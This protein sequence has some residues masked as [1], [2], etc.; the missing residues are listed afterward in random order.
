MSDSE[1]YAV[2]KGSCASNP[3]CLMSSMYR[4]W[5]KM[6]LSLLLSEAVQLCSLLYVLLAFKKKRYTCP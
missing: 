6:P 3:K 1:E 2:L 5:E 4:Y